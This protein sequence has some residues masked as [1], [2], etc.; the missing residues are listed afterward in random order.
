M[1]LLLHSESPY[2]GFS[3]SITM[4]ETNS[5]SDSGEKIEDGLRMRGEVKRING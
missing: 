4:E 2:G 1:C 5:D 3:L